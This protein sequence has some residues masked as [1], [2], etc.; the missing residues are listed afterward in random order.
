MKYAQLVKDN[1]DFL[2]LHSSMDRF[3]VLNSERK[4][5]HFVIYIPVWIDLKL[6]TLHHRYLSVVH[7]HSSMDRFEV[8]IADSGITALF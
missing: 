2:H 7:L 8:H 6:R 5:E 3:E 4:Q 1:D